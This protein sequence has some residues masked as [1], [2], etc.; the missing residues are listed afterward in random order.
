MVR[1]RYVSGVIAARVVVAQRHWS[2]GA[3]ARAP[4][5]Q[6]RQPTQLPGPPAPGAPLSSRCRCRRFSSS[7]SRLPQSD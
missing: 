4:V 2:C 7:I 6:H 1:N 3:A 5:A